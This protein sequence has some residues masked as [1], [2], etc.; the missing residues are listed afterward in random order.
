M[1]NL[2][3]KTIQTL[4]GNYQL[5]LSQNDRKLLSDITRLGIVTE[6]MAAQFCYEGSREDT[7][8]RRL[9]RL[10]EVGLLEK[11]EVITPTG[12]KWKSFEFKSDR[13]ARAF[14]GRKIAIGSKR[15]SYHECLVSNTY[16]E[17]GEPSDYRVESK[18][19]EHDLTQFRG[20]GAIRPDAIFTDKEGEV[21]LVEADSGQYT[22]SQITHKMHAWRGY[23]QHW[24]QPKNAFQKIQENETV[25][26][27]RY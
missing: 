8:S 24:V 11:K 2:K 22:K 27:T 3:T 13:L 16:Y 15:T 1:K 6:K 26:V 19:N 18:F 25:S 20:G 7:V 14:G 21:V 5:R 9:D 4:I 17:L 10:S 23:R 12:E